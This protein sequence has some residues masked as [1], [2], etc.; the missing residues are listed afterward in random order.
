[1]SDYRA[2][3]A[4]E[5]A[6]RILPLG[7]VTVICHVRPDADTLGSAAALCLV[8]SG[9]GKD[10]RLLSPDPIPDRLRFLTEG[11]RIT[12]RAEGCCIA[13]DVAAPSQLG[14]L[15]GT[16]IALTIDHHA[17]FTPFSDYYSVATASSAAEVLIDVIDAMGV[18]IAPTVAA[19]LYAAIS[20]DTGGFRYQNA[21]ARTMRCAARL[22]ECGIDYA[23]INHRLFN[24]KSAALI[25]AEGAVASR[26]RTAD[27][28]RIAYAVISRAER[29]ALG[30]GEEEL[31]TA[32][33]VVRTLEGAEI[34]LF[35]RENDDGTFRANLR[36]TG[37]DVSGVA[38]ELGGG[39]HTR[40][41][42]CSPVA[43]NC[44]SA[45]EM[46]IGKLISKEIRQ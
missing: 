41:A 16:E 19:R 26:I 34:A 46:I 1:M 15:A 6:R 8:L 14:R 45:A 36:S 18:S 2:V 42:A 11:I 7:R 29:D 13:V 21:S 28:G 10:A 44:E 38:A 20:A 23:D 3:S 37:P 17:V 43:R 4:E 25:R 35:V 12:D 39:G 40:A 33:D 24:S 9:L 5:C 32:I 27:G 30:I 22:M 31:G